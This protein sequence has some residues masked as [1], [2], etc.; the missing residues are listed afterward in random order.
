MNSDTRVIV[1]A[2]A[3]D[4]AQAENN[5][6]YYLHHQ[7][8]VTIMSP[9]DAPVNLG[10]ASG[11]DVTYRTG[12][13]RAY[14]GV[15]AIERQRVHLELM[16]D[17][18][19]KYFFCNDADS[20]CLTPELPAYLYAQSDVFWS[21]EISDCMHE[22]PEGYLLPRVALHPPWFMSRDTVEKFLMVADMVSVDL[23][24]PFIDHWFLQL[25]TACG[26]RHKDFVNGNTSFPTE[27]DE[28]HFGVLSGKVR[29][30]GTIFVHTVK[31]QRVLQRL[32]EDRK[33]FLQHER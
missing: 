31:S 19:E 27:N 13:K 6:P 4:A 15:D 18:P 9:D 2:Y 17:F 1:F 11:L 21:N 33:F 14:I 3:G 10:V 22:R 23:Q 25:A 16:L 30:Q 32:V 12:G 7:C 26:I 29:Y 24:T 8:P 20:L 28:F 5:L